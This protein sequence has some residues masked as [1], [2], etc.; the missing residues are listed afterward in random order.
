MGIHISETGGK[1]GTM[2]LCFLTIFGMLILT[3][4][5]FVA[6]VP[7]VDATSIWFYI[8]IVGG[9]LAGF[10]ISCF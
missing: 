4:V 5:H 2:L 10:A 8:I 6:D 9:V 3:I 1:I 7:N